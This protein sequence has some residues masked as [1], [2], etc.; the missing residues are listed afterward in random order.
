[1][2]EGRRRKRDPERRGRGGQS[3]GDELPAG[4]RPLHRPVPPPAR[5]ERDRGEGGEHVVGALGGEERERDQRDDHP[6]HEIAPAGLLAH[7]RERP[8][9]REGGHDPHPGRPRQG[10]QVRPPGLHLAPVGSRDPPGDLPAQPVLHEA[11]PA[12]GLDEVPGKR[13]EREGRRPRAGRRASP[14]R[15]QERV[16]AAH[17]SIGSAVHTKTTGP[18]VRNPAPRAAHAATRHARDPPGRVPRRAASTA[19]TT[20]RAR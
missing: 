3:A 17:A 16:Q 14:T 11:R 20:Q 2:S 18:L 6:R 9:P 8:Q 13:E 5:G 19:T 15:A 10:Q 12:R 1:M 7:P 4:C